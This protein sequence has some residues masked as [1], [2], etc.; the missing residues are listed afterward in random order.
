M[1]HHNQTGRIRGNFTV[2]EFLALETI[3][4]T[5][6]PGLRNTN[7]IRLSHRSKRT[8]A[9]SVLGSFIT[10]D[11]KDNARVPSGGLFH[12]DTKSDTPSVRIQ[13]YDVIVDPTLAL[14]PKTSMGPMN[15]DLHP[16]RKSPLS[17]S[18]N[19]FPCSRCQ[20]RSWVERK[21]SSSFTPMVML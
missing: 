15:V 21:R 19:L 18:S 12:I 10:I 6:V 13:F 3:I 2:A 1:T 5:S 9:L 11:S 20:G 7:N 8:P 4:A 14:A 16:T 17:L